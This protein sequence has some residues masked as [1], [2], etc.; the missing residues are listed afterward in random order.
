M[1]SPSDVIQYLERPISDVIR[2]IIR[3]NDTQGALAI[4]FG[5]TVER[6]GELNDITR[7]AVLRTGNIL[8]I[9]TTRPRITVRTVDEETRI[10]TIPRA[11]ETIEN[12]DMLR[13]APPIIINEGRDGQQ[14]VMHRTTRLNGV[15]VGVTEVIPIR[16]ITEPETRIEEIGTA[17]TVTDVR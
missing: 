9:E 17:E 1:D 10:E 16:T 4:E 6:I 14:E 7:E 2:H 8:F 11:V 12:H 15:Q 3:Q 13:T 5:T